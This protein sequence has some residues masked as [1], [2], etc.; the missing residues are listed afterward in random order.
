MKAYTQVSRKSVGEDRVAICP[1]FGCEYITRVKPLKLRFLGFGK[2][3]K[4]KKHHIP[5]VYIDDRIGDFVDA[6]LACLFDKA[7]LPPSELIEDVKSKFPDE[8]KSF[9]EGWVYCITIGRGAPVVSRYMDTISNA[10]LKQLTKKQ[11]K[12]L[13][14]GDDSKPNLVK[15]A[16]KDGIDEITIQFS[17]IL[18]HLRAHSEILIDHQKIKP[19]SKDLKKYLDDWHKNVIKHNEIVNS[20]KNKRQMDSKEIKC[21]YDQILN[22]GTCRC[23]LGF[24]PETKEI[25]KSKITAFDRFSAYHDFYNEELTIKF[26]KSDILILLNNNRQNRLEKRF[27]VLKNDKRK[28]NIKEDQTSMVHD[29]QISN[30]KILNFQKEVINHIKNLIKLIECIEDQK[31][32][33]LSNSEK[34]LNEHISRAEMGEI[35]ILSHVNPLKN[36]VAIIY[37]VL[38]SNENMPKLSQSNLS[39]ITGI[40]QSTIAQLYNKYYKIFAQKLDF[41]FQSAQLGRNVISLYFFELLMDQEIDTSEIVLHLR[42]TIINTDS[43]REHCLL[44]QLTEN[45]IKF[46]QDMVI[47]YPETFMKYFSDLVNIIKLLVISNNFHKIISAD[48]STK[49]FALY[50]IDKKIN[51]FLGQYQFVDVIGEIFNFLVEKYPEFFAD[52]AN[53]I[54]N[55]EREDAER[56]T[57]IGSRIKLYVLKHIYKGRY[58]DFERGIASCPKC[59]VEKFKINTSFP[60]IRSKD[61]H[62]KETRIEGFESRRLYR[63]FTSNRGNPY[64]LSMLINKMEKRSVSLRCKSHHNIIKAVHYRYFKKFIS[65]ENIPSEFPQ[66]IFELPAE[67][68]HILAMIC[69][70]NFYKTKTKNLDERLP[71]RRGLIHKLKKRYIIELVN[72][73]ICPAC[74]EF[75]TREHLPSFHFNHLYESSEVTIEEKRRREEYKISELYRTFSCSELVGEMER[76]KGGYICGNC[77]FVIHTKIDLIDKIYDDKNI[78][79][80][81]IKDRNRTIKNFEQNIIHHSKL[82]KDPLKLDMKQESLSLLKYFSALYEISEEKSVISSHDLE[83]K[84]RISRSSALKFFTKRKE[85]LEKFGNIIPARGRIPIKYYMNDDGKRIVWLMHYFKNYYKNLK[86]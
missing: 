81:V 36:A 29:S 80:A 50:L 53:T 83:E 22:V 84:M 28:L 62:H 42:N 54:E 86:S 14:K 74:G 21:N 65:W 30:I 19:L 7:G 1:D 72:G 78:I 15:K 59:L 25:N 11:I 3:P 8:L 27:V 77:H 47:N 44:K 26:T 4:C 48:F 5:L 39:K 34:I 40:N 17:R 20:P 24:N 67:I 73:G 49:K 61:F 32:I 35:I 16:I 41:N 60:R 9:V 6:A 69:V 52:R 13:K 12:A 31:R 10:Y 70:D 18:K 46:L 79:K 43:L 57:V 75:N 33:I 55:E 38:V 51:L 63:L 45:E 85:L 58:F 2:H 56:T 37:A 23:L 64:F 68:I 82:I 76:Q 71:I 66:N